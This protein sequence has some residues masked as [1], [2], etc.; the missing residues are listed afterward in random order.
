MS[1]AGE[2][3]E[4]TTLL[5]TYLLTR[6]TSCTLFVIDG[7]KVVFNLDRAL[8]TGFLTLSASDTAVM[9]YLAHLRALVVAGALDNHAGGV[10]DEADN[11]VGTFLHA[12][13]AADAL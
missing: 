6:S 8:G 9:A 3:F 7:S 4:V 5:R 2:V 13:A 11:A 10:V 12:E 1:A